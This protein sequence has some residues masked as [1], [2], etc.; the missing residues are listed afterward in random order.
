MGIEEIV[1]VK[2]KSDVGWWAPRLLEAWRHR[3]EA[4]MSDV[5][6]VCHGES[7]RR[8]WPRNLCRPH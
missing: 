6:K 8:S 2:S 4:P 5:D 1:T 7:A 3:C